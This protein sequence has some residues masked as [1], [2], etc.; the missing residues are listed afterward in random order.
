[1]YHKRKYS[2]KGRGTSSLWNHLKAC[3]KA[4]YDD[5]STEQAKQAKEKEA[6][7][8]PLQKAKSEVKQK[9]IAECFPSVK[10]W[11]VNSFR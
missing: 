10:I 11:D 4:E 2:Q 9:S 6:E 3:H 7:K 5:L 1:M 8:T